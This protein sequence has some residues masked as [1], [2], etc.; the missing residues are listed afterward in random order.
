MIMILWGVLQETFMALI[1]KIAF[2]I[3]FERM[4]TRLVIFG[5]KKLAKQTTNEVVE[6]TVYDIIMSLQGKKLKV[7]EDEI[8]S[9]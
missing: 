5:L 6:K 4:F 2:R 3:I 1:G 8:K 9:L 7:V